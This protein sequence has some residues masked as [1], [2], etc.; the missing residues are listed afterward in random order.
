[1]GI[2][3]GVVVVQIFI[4]ISSKYNI[5]VCDRFIIFSFTYIYGAIFSFVLEVSRLLCIYEV[6]PNNKILLF[7]SAIGLYSLFNNKL[8]SIY[9]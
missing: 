9:H 1:M 8:S 7:I 2:S 4:P 5:I 6:Q 3:S